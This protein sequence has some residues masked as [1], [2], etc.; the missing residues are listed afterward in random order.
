MKM[1]LLNSESLELIP[2]LEALFAKYFRDPENFRSTT[3]QLKCEP[4]L[5]ATFGNL[6]RH[7]EEAKNKPIG[8]YFVL[9][10][11][12]KDGTVACSDAWYLDH[13]LADFWSH[14]T[15]HVVEAERCRHFEQMVHD[16][17]RKRGGLTLTIQTLTPVGE[18]A[19]L[20]QLSLDAF[21]G[22]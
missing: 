6:W 15:M 4:R 1:K 14:E 22:R 8:R 18:P 19:E 16:R 17:S 7:A 13:R 5:Y 12:C 10:G 2:E 9:F 21:D 3:V 20:S 11:N